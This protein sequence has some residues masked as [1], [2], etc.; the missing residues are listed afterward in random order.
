MS[1]RFLSTILG[2]DANFTGNVGVGTT[3]PGAKLDVSTNAGRLRITQN[4][5]GNTLNGLEFAAYN[6][7]VLGGVLFN[8]STGEIRLN[9]ISSYFP[10]IYSNGAEVVRIP[11]SGNVLIGTTTDAGYKLDVNGNSRIFS[12]GNTRLY[13]DTTSATPNTGFALSVSGTAKWTVGAYKPSGTNLSYVL[14][15]EQ[16]GTNSLFIQGDTNNVII[17][18]TTDAGYKLDVLGTTRFG[19]NSLVTLNQNA[20]TSF[21]VSNTTSGTNSSAQ[22]KTTSSGGSMQLGKWSG[23]S[24]TY[25][26]LVAND[27]FLYNSGSG[28]ISILNDFSTGNI[29]FA[30]RGS[31]AA[32]VIMNGDSQPLALVGGGSSNFSMNSGN[33]VYFAFNSQSAVGRFYANPQGTVQYTYDQPTSVGFVGTLAGA[34]VWYG[35]MNSSGGAVKYNCSLNGSAHSHIWY[36][37]FS[38]QMRLAYTGNLLI[39][40]STDAGYKLDVNGIARVITRIDAGNFTPGAGA[41]AYTIATTGRISAGDGI[42]FRSPI[43]G[44]STFNGFTTGGY[45]VAIYVGNATVGS[46]GGPGGSTDPMLNLT[47]AFNPSSG[48]TNK[49]TLLL[50]PVYQTSGTYSGGIIGLYYN[51]TL[52]SIA[53]TAYHR[54]IQTVT[55]DVIFGSTSGNVGI[56]TTTP[57]G[58]LHVI[59]A[60]GNGTK[61]TTSGYSNWGSIVSFNNDSAGGLFGLDIQAYSDAGGNRIIN[62]V[63]NNTTGINFPSGV[64]VS[65]WSLYGC[66]YNSFWQDAVLYLRNTTGGTGGFKFTSVVTGVLM[67]ILENGRVLIGSTTDTG[68]KL[69]VTGTTKIS[70]L[71]GGGTQM[72]VADNTGVLSVQA[73]P[74]IPTK[75][76][77]AWQE[78]TT[79]TA[80]SSNTGY[81][82]KFSTPD[83]SGYG[84]NVINDPFGDA[85]YIEMVNNGVYN[86]QFSLQLQ[87][88][89]GQIKDVTIWL[90]KNGNTSFDDIPATAGFV[91]V[92]NS[93]GGTPGT[94]IAAWNYFVEA[95]A[96][97]FYQL[98]WSTSDHTRVSIEFYPAG[99]PPPSAASAILTVNQVN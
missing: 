99:S 24:T 93:H 69:Q 48:S 98:V 89:D 31:S 49:T 22:I 23:T 68:Q 38:E 67:S 33:D 47:S 6:G 86:I 75:S 13:I 95:A 18:S 9:T 66:Y 97:D 56:G 36:Y 10:T 26:I 94:I 21:T 5:V 7:T 82:V 20:E 54:A 17:G 92:P 37:N 83:I 11:T 58:K 15:N 30:A 28:N 73:I 59:G 12:S 55:G 14:Y 61:I 43:Y 90:R 63:G 91:S 72:V 70:S 87:N 79:Q 65:S 80:P 8:Q 46:F 81:G 39:G 77:G 50:N 85:T 29:N 16:T 51:P 62:I 27:G 96:G 1:Y 45:G 76:F 19:G 64:S 74:S 71:G 41:T 3:T 44:D 60:V 4:I 35:N 57:G 53:G 34:S 84:V 42:T 2:I 88:T 40:T 52:T 32:Q 78:D 25:K